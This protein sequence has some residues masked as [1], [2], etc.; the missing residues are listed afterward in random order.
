MLDLFRDRQSSMRILL[1]VL[2]SL[3]ALSMVV[4]LIPGFGSP[5][6]NPEDDQVLAVVGDDKVMA[7]DIRNRI[8]EL[9]RGQRLP[10]QLVS[11]YVPQLIDGAIEERA[12]ALM[13]EML[14]NRISDDELARVIRGSLPS[15]FENGAV[16]KARYRDAVAGMGRTVQQFEED[17]RKNQLGLRIRNMAEESALVSPEDVEKEYKRRNVK[18]KIEYVAFSSEKMKSQVVA[19]DAD[20]KALYDNGKEAYPVPEK[21]NMTVVVADEAQIAAQIDTP[22]ALLRA[23]YDKQKDRFRTPDRVRV[24]HILIMT[25]GK[26]EAEKANLKKKAEDIL[27]QVKGGADFAELAKK[28]SEDPL[29]A[30]KGGD[31]DWFGRGRMVPNFENAAFALK[32]GQ[33]SDLV[34]TEYGYHVIQSQEKEDAK[35]KPFDEVKGQIIAELKG[36]QVR[37]RTQKAIEDAR[38]EAI[39]NPA[40]LE[41]I[42][43]KHGLQVIKGEDIAMGGALPS[44]GQASDLISSA[45]GARQGGITS[46]VQPQTGKLAFATVTGITPARTATFEEAREKIKES[47]QSVKAQELA[48]S[49]A[50]EAAAKLLP[51]GTDW[52]SAA[53]GLGAELKT[54]EE[55]GPDGSIDGLGGATMLGDLL[56]KPQGAAAG[57]ISVLGQWVVARLVERKEPDAAGLVAQRT[58]IQL[59]LKQKTS[60]SRYNLIRDSILNTLIESGKVKKNKK[61]I[62]RL[63]A[64]Y[65]S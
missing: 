54:S 8:D 56:D 18:Y 7:R 33:I 1:V 12:E 34:T 60:Q 9:V 50:K 13:S 40:A 64:A 57:P 41:Q 63:L 45:F 4:T 24:R 38:A 19:N 14:G 51:P 46:I 36:T 43:A 53:K 15:L 49:K 27:K 39:K 31:M 30:V 47:Y 29:S 65:S 62:E 10:P 20:L 16:D 23:E 44:L 28:N 6:I 11:A 59:N 35:L 61:A 37:E 32:P 21:R 22:E 26:P 48:Q 52:K 58:S 55:F 3:V 17:L 5:S 42:A 2:L 25:Q